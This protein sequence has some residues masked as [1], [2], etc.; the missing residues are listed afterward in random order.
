FYDDYYMMERRRDLRD[1]YRDTAAD[2]NGSVDSI[3]ARLLTAEEAQ[4]V[5][6]TV[7]SSGG[8][9]L[10]DTT[11]RQLTDEISATMPH[12]GFGGGG[13]RDAL[14]NDL[15]L[16]ARALQSADAELLSR[17]GCDIV[18]VTAEQSEYLCLVGRLGDHYLISRTA[19]AYMESN[20][21]FNSTFLL[22]AG[23]FS[24]L[25]C[26]AAAWIISRR[27]TAPLVQMSR[28]AD[29]MAGLDFSQKVHTR[30][31]DEVAQLGRSL[32]LLSEHLERAVHELQRSNDDLSRE[33]EEK[34]RIDAMRREFIINVSH[35]LKT[36]IALIRGYAEGLREGVAEDPEDRK[37]YC[38]TICDEAVRMNEMVLGLL[39]LSKLED[40]RETAEYAPVDLQ[41][42]CA[43]AADKVAP[44]AS[45]RGL[46]I[47]N[48]VQPVT[49]LSDADLLDRILGNYLTNAIRYTPDGGAIR[50]S[51]DN[52]PDGGT[53][54]RVYNEGDGVSEDELDRLW[55]KFYR[56]DKA[57]S[58][59]SGGT[60]IGLSIVRAAAELLHGR[61]WAANEQNGIAFYVYLPPDA[62]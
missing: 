4:G 28:A 9:V 48:T 26:I 13:M 8:T 23:F 30:G 56:T 22:I 51:A 39:S 42:L 43:A 55:D 38:D 33:N 40:G 35:E 6:L 2:Y 25:V 44:L 27:F 34:A 29:A 52:A 21:V 3:Y 11:L 18:T 46:Q 7:L 10:Y 41:V 20:S 5:R 37:Y 1:L 24:L 54:L 19:V 12:A 50:I 53:V 36:P 31:E 17:E 60:G 62:S 59:E 47:S 32:N 58:R 14:F 61:V 15:N 16:T 57:R 45:D 49:I